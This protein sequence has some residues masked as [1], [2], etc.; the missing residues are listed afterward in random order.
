M[1]NIII[2]LLR[3]LVS[4]CSLAQT[5]TDAIARPGG[6]SCTQSA[7]PAVVQNTECVLRSNKANYNIFTGIMKTIIV[8]VKIQNS[9]RLKDPKRVHLYTPSWWKLKCWNCPAKENNPTLLK[10]FHMLGDSVRE[11]VPPRHT[12]PTVPTHVSITNITPHFSKSVYATVYSLM[13]TYSGKNF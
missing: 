1:L 9:V 3:F 4:I 7:K 2:F 10:Y 5:L 8:V 12:G 13:G 6:E 11:T